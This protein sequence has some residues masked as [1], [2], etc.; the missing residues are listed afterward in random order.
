VQ[1]FFALAILHQRKP[2]GDIQPLT[3]E[4]ES[5]AVLTEY[6]WDNHI[7]GLLMW[8]RGVSLLERISP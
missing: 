3:V 5:F 4:G 8:H 6:H 2:I 7:G 1:Q